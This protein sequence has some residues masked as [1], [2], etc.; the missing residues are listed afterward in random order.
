[1]R[2]GGRWED[3]EVQAA[4][5]ARPI[6]TGARPVSGWTLP[7]PANGVFAA[8]VGTGFDSRQLHV[9]GKLAPRAQIAVASSAI[10]H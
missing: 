5:G 6:F 2:L 8:K 1:M 9:N 7:D 4:L 3:R 10:T